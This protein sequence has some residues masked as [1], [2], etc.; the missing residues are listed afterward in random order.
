M[1][2][3][4]VGNSVSVIQNNTG[5]ASQSFSFAAKVDLKAGTNPQSVAIGDLNGD[6]KPDI[7][8]A[9]KGGNGVSVIS[10]NHTQG[11]IATASFN[12]KKDF[13]TGNAPVFV[14]LNDFTGDGK[15]DILVASSTS[16]SI[17]VLGNISAA[18]SIS[19][20]GKI[21]IATGSGLQ[22]LVAGDMDGDGKPD[23]AFTNFAINKVSLIRNAAIA[24]PPP[25]ITSFSPKT[26]PASTLVTINGTNFN[27]DAAKNLVVFGAVSAKPVSATATKITVRVPLGATQQGLTVLNLATGLAGKAAAPYVI[28]YSGKSIMSEF[29]FKRLPI[30]PRTGNYSETKVADINGDGKSDIVALS[31]Y[32]SRVYM[33][34]NIS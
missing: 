19:F 13:A 32:N 4:N 21:D 23:I 22:S 6:G 12:D 11:N 7:I 20:F 27:T 25:V 26:G 16:N 29:D 31:T 9:N 28:T 33:Q 2:G 8:T 24:F 30:P 34:R 17:S 18:G 10:N 3:G 14:T 5:T 15:V 1:I